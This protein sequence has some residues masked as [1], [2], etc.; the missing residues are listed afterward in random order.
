MSTLHF[1]A[2][3]D[4]GDEIQF[5]SPMTGQLDYECVMTLEEMESYKGYTGKDYEILYAEGPDGD[6]YNIT[7]QA[8]TWD[9]AKIQ[10]REL[11]RNTEEQQL[12]RQLIRQQD[13]I[14]NSKLRGMVR[15]AK[16]ERKRL[17]EE[18]EMCKAHRNTLYNGGVW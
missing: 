11:A 13:E 16:S 4:A 14:I 12:L 17:N 3:N 15:A 5:Y 2:T 9:H 7:A 8:A 18:L 6:I 10:D 1:Y